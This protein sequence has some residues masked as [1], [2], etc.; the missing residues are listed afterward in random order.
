VLDLQAGTTVVDLQDFAYAVLVNQDCDL[1]QDH[2]ARKGGGATAGHRRIVEAILVEAKPALEVREQARTNLNIGKDLWKRVV[3]NK[4]ERF[5]FVEGPPM[6]LD[7]LGEGLPDLALD[8][9]GCFSMRMEELLHRIDLGPTRRR[10][11][12]L[13][14]WAEHLSSRFAYFYS[15]VGLPR[16]HSIRGAS[17]AEPAASGPVTTL[18]P[19]GRPEVL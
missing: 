12:L 5:H 18:P 9:R 14:P 17:L 3:Q 16:D 1:E 11:W 7:A 4:D 8:F 19:V 15:R 2:T 6:D 13:T 10:A